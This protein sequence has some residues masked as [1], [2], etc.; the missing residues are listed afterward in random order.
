[1]CGSARKAATT[2][3][4]KTAEALASVERS[5]RDGLDPVGVRTA[6]E[7][8][9]FGGGHGCVLGDRPPMIK[10]ESEYP[11]DSA[12]RDALLDACFGE[13]RT[14]RS[15]ESLRVGQVP[16]PGLSFVARD[17]AR[18]VGT[19]RLWPITLVDMLAGG[20]SSAVLLGPLAVDPAYRGQ[21]LSKALM[22]HVL[23]EADMVGVK[24]IFLVGDE[25]L[26]H[27]YGFCRTAPCHITLPGGRDAD[28]LMVRQ[29]GALKA[30]PGV[31]QLIPYSADR[32]GERPAVA[33]ASP[34][35]EPLYLSA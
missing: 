5:K 33:S 22:H 26:Y 32:A 16:A 12:A 17:G 34:Y 8:T 19:V 9:R 2:T 35:G 7:K 24:R 15:A 18:L 27:P 21:K 28:R 4:T 13:G 30:L 23:D 29:T 11:T 1:M 31:G 10:I 25:N 20:T 14:N 6:F 3:L